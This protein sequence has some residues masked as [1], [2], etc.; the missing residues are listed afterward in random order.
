MKLDLK[1][2]MEE[3]QDLNKNL[4]YILWVLI[5]L[6]GIILGAVIAGGFR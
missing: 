6:S 4:T 3:L 5:I 1:E 2:L